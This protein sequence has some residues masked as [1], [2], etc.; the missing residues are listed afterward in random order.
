[1]IAIIY[2]QSLQIPFVIR[3]RISSMNNLHSIGDD[4]VG[5]VIEIRIGIR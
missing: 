1:M 2:S 5:N 3:F 4:I